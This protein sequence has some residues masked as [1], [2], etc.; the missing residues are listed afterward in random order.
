EH[1]DT[2]TDRASR[3]WVER[4]ATT[5]FVGTGYVTTEPDSGAVVS[6]N[7]ATT[8]PQLDYRVNFDAPGTYRL[9]LRAIGPNASGDSVHVGIDGATTV[10]SENFPVG[11]GT[12]FAWRNKSGT[13][14]IQ[15][16]S[17]GVHT[18][19]LWMRED[20]ASVDR[21]LLTTNTG[22][23]PTGD[24]PAESPRGGGGGPPIDTTAPLV[25]SSTPANAAT[26]VAISTNA[27]VTFNEAMNPA[28]VTGAR[29]SLAPAAGGAAV[30]AT[31]TPSAG[32]T[33]FTLDPSV[34]L[35]AGVQ[36]RVTLDG[37]VTDVA[38]NPLGAGQQWTFT[39][40]AAGGGG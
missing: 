2:R 3:S 37:A 22:L 38:G 16:P 39:T 29:F 25:S 27:S 18:I 32:N 33:V 9:W 23:T 40:A 10:D 12:A 19:N 7:P 21:I 1:F 13:A 26:G 4:T 5:G 20:G 11:A 36:Y 6:T 14:V 34:D 31:I 30:A 8:S 15:V 28:S 17:A 35:T 24:G